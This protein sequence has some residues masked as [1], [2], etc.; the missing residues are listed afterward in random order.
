MIAESP[1][2]GGF[3]R[4]SPKQDNTKLQQQIKVLLT[5]CKQQ[6]TTIKEL[7]QNYF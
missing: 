7:K 4:K 3:T 1:P 5:V 6:Y 2:R